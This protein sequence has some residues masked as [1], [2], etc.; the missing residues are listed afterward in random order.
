MRY[1]PDSK[2]ESGGQSRYQETDCEDVED[3]VCAAVRV[4]YLQ[5]K[6]VRVE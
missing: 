1:V 3:F 2:D 4:C 5:L 6:C